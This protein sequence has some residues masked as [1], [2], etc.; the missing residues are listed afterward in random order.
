MARDT[1][2]QLRHGPWEDQDKGSSASAS[3][4]VVRVSGPLLDCQS[5]HLVAEGAIQ[6]PWGVM[7]R[8]EASL[9]PTRV[10]MPPPFGPWLR[11]QRH[12]SGLSQAEMAALLDTSVQSV[13]GW[14]K[15][16]RYPRRD[17]EERYRRRIAEVADAAVRVEMTLTR[18][19]DAIADERIRGAVARRFGVA[20]AGAEAADPHAFRFTPPNGLPD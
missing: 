13:M 5:L 10:E 1:L 17:V 11:Q 9:T 16:R 2:T 20:C 15:E 4:V 14:E 12:R 19:L 3:G 18:A 6:L 8:D 7:S